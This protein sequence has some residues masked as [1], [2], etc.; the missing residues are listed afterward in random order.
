[1]CRLFVFVKEVWNEEGCLKLVMNQLNQFY[2]DVCKICSDVKEHLLFVKNKI[3]L[4]FYLNSLIF[5][6]IFLLLQNFVKFNN[7]N[8]KIAHS[9]KNQHYL[10][11][12]VLF[13]KWS[14]LSKSLI[15]FWIWKQFKC[16]WLLNQWHFFSFFPSIFHLL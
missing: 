8:K 6:L 3:K 5:H 7:K 10:F 4:L 11:A 12:N 16:W 2:N 15:S 9:I 14:L 1:M 13:V